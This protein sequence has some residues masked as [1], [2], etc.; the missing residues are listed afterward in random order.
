MR[1]YKSFCDVGVD[2]VVMI[3]VKKKGMEV[4]FF[5]KN[6]PPHKKSNEFFRLSTVEKK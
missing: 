1:F 2:E 6:F 5:L 3:V 4:N